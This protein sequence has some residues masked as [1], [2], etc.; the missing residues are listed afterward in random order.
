MD[1]SRVLAAC[2]EHDKIQTIAQFIDHVNGPEYH[3]LVSVVTPAYS[4]PATYLLSF[5]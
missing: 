3:V 1:Q 4:A 2:D 5:L